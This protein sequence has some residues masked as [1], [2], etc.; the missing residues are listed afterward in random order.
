MTDLLNGVVSMLS[1]EF[2]VYMA[3]FINLVKS[4]TDELARTLDTPAQ[5]K[6]STPS[7]G[8]E[9]K[10]E[11][12]NKIKALEEEKRDIGTKL[13]QAE[14]SLENLRPLIK[15]Y[16]TKCRELDT[17]GSD[18]EKLSIWYHDQVQSLYASKA[19]FETTLSQKNKKIQELESKLSS[20][21]LKV[22]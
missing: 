7:S 4:K 13:K 18:S 19:D 8:S 16:N 17:M 11:L 2:N 6:D 14:A 9:K 5:Q 3:K 20:E 22:S 15:S 21:S 10:K 1:K 12:E